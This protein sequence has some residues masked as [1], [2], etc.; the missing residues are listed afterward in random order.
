MQVVGDELLL[1]RVAPNVARFDRVGDELAD[2]RTEVVVGPVDVL[3]PVEQGRE[4][5][6]GWLIM[7]SLESDLGRLPLAATA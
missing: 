1:R 4:H 2:H 6:V 3:I 7:P 5:G